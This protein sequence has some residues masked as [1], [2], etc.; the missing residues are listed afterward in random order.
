MSERYPAGIITNNAVTPSGPYQN[1]TAPGIWTLDQQISWQKAG[2]WP[3]QGSINPSLF[4]ENLFSTYL[5]TGDNT[6]T[7]TITTNLNFSTYGGLMWI[8][9]RNGTVNNALS[10][11]ARGYGNILI[12]D[13]T[14][15]N[16]ALQSWL[17]NWTT[18]GFGVTNG[19]NY[20]ASGATYASWNFRKQA[21]FFDIVTYTGTGSATTIAHNLGSVPGCIIVKRTDTTS[22]WQVYH[23]GLTSAAYSIQLNLTAAQASATT[24][25]N[26]TAPTSS[27]FSVGTG[28]TVNASGGTYVAYIFA[29]NAGGFGSDGTQNVI[30]CGT[31]TSSSSPTTVTLGYEPQWVMVKDSTNSSQWYMFD[32][33]RGMSNTSSQ[34]LQASI[35]NAESTLNP[36]AIIP[37]ATG[38]IDN[39][40][41]VGAGDTMIYIAIRRG[42]MAT[43]T[44]GT[45]V[46]SPQTATYS[47]NQ[48]V[49]TGFPVDLTM[50][51]GRTITLGTI[52]YDRLRGLASTNTSPVDPQLITSDTSAETSGDYVNTA[53]NTGYQISPGFS[54]FSSVNWNFQRAPGFFDIVCYTGNGSYTQNVNHNLTVPFEMAIL[55]RRSSGTGQDM[56]W[57]VAVKNQ[58]NV[59]YWFIGTGNG[60]SSNAAA[61]AS[62]DW[63]AAGGATGDTST[64][65]QPAFV[66]QANPGGY[67]SGQT[68][69]AYLFASLAG[70]SKVGS[71]SGTGA[72]QTINCG[73]TGGARFVL[74]KRTDS[75]GDWYVWDTARGMVAGTDPYLLLDTTA[76]EV[77]ANN[78]YTTTGGFQIV[79]SLADINASG[80]TYIFL[81]IA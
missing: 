16:Q 44:S 37:T 18:T 39:A 81:A 48:V 60:L 41:L 78:V 9:Q 12:S 54:G 61:A 56:I 13:G 5:Y 63:T 55:K 45:S 10:D 79:S 35:A 43:P 80:G 76:A 4:I 15:A 28:A 71:Y 34:L 26:S 62:A 47:A 64:L 19:G 58:S 65:F 22:N 24:V 14:Y 23:S 69:V 38:F 52:A 67:T 20:N 29:S 66:S 72:T 70:V 36:P 31:Y 51:K 6:A 25:W 53:N 33:M 17:T 7:Q 32:N 1:S 11:T 40:Q 49:T 74:I 73:F 46:F 8:K 3:T 50:I 42:P 68:Y 27:V 2:Q 57:V 75:T 30:T 77:N 21:K 59:G